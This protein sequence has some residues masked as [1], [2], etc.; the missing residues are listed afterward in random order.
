M[1]DVCPSTSSSTSSLVSSGTGDTSR[2]GT[3]RQAQ[4][5]KANGESVVPIN[6]SAA[7]YALRIAHHELRKGTIAKAGQFEPFLHPACLCNKPNNQTVTILK[8]MKNLEIETSILISKAANEVFIAIVDPKH[9]SNYFISKSSGVMEEGKTLTWEFPEFDM[10]FPVHIKTI[11]E[12]EY[13]NYNW[14]GT[15]NEILSVEFKLETRGQSTLVTVIEK[16]MPDNDAG[17]AWLKNNT[18][19]WAN[20]L[21]CLKAYLEFGINLRK[22]GFDH[23]KTN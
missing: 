3:L 17:I 19:G 22:G 4:G 11:R 21:A 6:M 12:N 16:S 8:P 20:F 15:D 1:N 14:E 7:H 18:A 13:I 2:K 9:M 23:L 10:T 5:P